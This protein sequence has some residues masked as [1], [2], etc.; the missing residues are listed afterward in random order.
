MVASFFSGLLPELLVRG[1][2]PPTDPVAGL[3][4]TDPAVVGPPWTMQG[5]SVLEFA[6]FPVDLVRPYIPQDVDIVQT[7]PGYSLGAV[8]F[9]CY[10]QTPIGSYNELV[11][12]PALVRYRS[13]LGLWVTN[14]DVDSETSRINGRVNWG[15]PKGITRFTYRWPEDLAGEAEFAV[16]QEGEQEPFLT[17]TAVPT[18]QEIPEPEWLAPVLQNFKNF[19]LPLKLAGSGMLTYRQ[20]LYWNTRSEFE[21]QG[22]PTVLRTRV[23]AGVEGAYRVIDQRQPLVGLRF[24]RFT[25]RLEPPQV[26]A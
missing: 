6:Q 13:A 17:A 14:I 15:L 21:G 22:H 26:L 19:A 12:A 5:Q 9:I 20:G 7:W 2:A 11:L 3:D 24:P 23:R 16:V 4:P 10:D 1:T 18:L 8:L 25:L